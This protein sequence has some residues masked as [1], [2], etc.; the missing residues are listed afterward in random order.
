[1]VHFFFNYVRCASFLAFSELIY[2]LACHCVWDQQG[3]FSQTSASYPS[4][5]LG[6]TNLLHAAS[7]GG[8]YGLL[9]QRI[10]K[11]YYDLD[12]MLSGA[13]AGM[14]NPLRGLKLL[15]LSFLGVYRCEETYSTCLV[16][17]SCVGPVVLSSFSAFAI[18]LCCKGG[19]LPSPK[20]T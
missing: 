13:I 9:V 11:N 14:G 8:L 10:D 12:S 6:T 2:P 5:V 7:S 4:Q 16:W 19:Y 20:P 17:Q 15:V 3:I 1:M 18:P